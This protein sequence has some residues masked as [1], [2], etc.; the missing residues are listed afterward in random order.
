[1][2]LFSKLLSLST[3]SI[4]IE[5]FFTEIIAYLFARNP[6]LLCKWLDSIGIIDASS[7]TDFQVDTQRSFKPLDGHSSGSRQTYQL[8]PSIK[9]IAFLYLSKAK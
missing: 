9:R 8:R 2:S 1:M 3:G 4:L 5:D 7:Y 6:D